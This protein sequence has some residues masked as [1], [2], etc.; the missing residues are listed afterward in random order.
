[1]LRGILSDPADQVDAGGVA[2]REYD[3]CSIREAADL[4]RFVV[5]VAN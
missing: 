5:A 3:H 1:M 4:R 2:R